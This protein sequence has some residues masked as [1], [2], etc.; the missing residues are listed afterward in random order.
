MGYEN[1]VCSPFFNTDNYER[2][3]TLSVSFFIHEIYN[4]SYD[5]SQE[6]YDPYDSF[7][8]FSQKRECE[9]LSVN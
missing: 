7:K 4:D 1:G 3:T 8:I 6:K 2:L 5:H 9:F